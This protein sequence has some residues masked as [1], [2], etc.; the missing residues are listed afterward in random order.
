M[1]AIHSVAKAVVC[2]QKTLMV[3]A[4]ARRMC[5][6]LVMGYEHFKVWDDVSDGC[7][8]PFHFLWPFNT[9]NDEQSFSLRC[10]FF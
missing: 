8:E 10:N 4:A 6:W 3:F 2:H 7:L 9:W 5:D 1:L